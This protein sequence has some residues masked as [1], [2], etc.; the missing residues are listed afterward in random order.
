MDSIAHRD[1]NR[2][3]KGQS[4]LENRIFTQ[5]AIVQDNSQKTPLAVISVDGSKAFDRLNR[6][7]L[8]T[9]FK[10]FGFGEDSL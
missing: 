2:S 6:S 4:I 1:Q 5:D 8:F 7:F 9:S 10:K 3:K